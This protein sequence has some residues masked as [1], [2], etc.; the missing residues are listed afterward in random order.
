MNV[1]P[2][3]RKW[4]RKEAS[5]ARLDTPKRSESIAAIVERLSL[6]ARNQCIPPGN[7]RLRR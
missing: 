2:R 5:G 1:S 3:F 6:P 7:S 4:R